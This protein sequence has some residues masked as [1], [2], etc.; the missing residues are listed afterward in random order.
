[1]ATVLQAV[2]DLACNRPAQIALRIRFTDDE[3]WTTLH[4]VCSPLANYLRPQANIDFWIEN[5]T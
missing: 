3:P 4:A 5:N 2:A 1:M